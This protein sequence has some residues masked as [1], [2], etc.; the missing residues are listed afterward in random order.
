[1]EQKRRLR[2]LEKISETDDTVTFR[3]DVADGQP[4]TY[5]P[6]QHVTLIF[7]VN[8]HEKRRA[9]S[10]SSSPAT[11][12]YPA[13]TVKRV[14]NGEFS[15]LLLYRRAV[16]E[17]FTTTEANG[18]FLLPKRLPKSLFYIAAG[19]GITPIFSHLKTLLTPGAKRAGL[20]KIVLFYAN[21]DSRST[22][23]KAQIDRWMADYPGL[24]DC[25]YFFSREKN[26]EHARFRHLNNEL[27]EQELRRSFGGQLT[28]QHRRTSLFY[29][30]APQAMMRTARMTLRQ[31]DFPEENMHFEAFAPAIAPTVRRINTAVTH[32]IIAS[33]PSERIEFQVFDDETI[34]DGALR[35]GIALPYSCK[36]GVC[37]T[38]LT[39][40]VQGEVDM[41]FAQLT[42]RG[43]PGDM[44]NTCIGYAA[45]DSV[46]IRYE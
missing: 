4:F 9:Y 2:L 36:S 29:F 7:E 22:I 10:F 25:V 19:S 18:H 28:A 13:I 38:C 46:E 17:I 3:L 44:V 45:T 30:C 14:P 40:C 20:Q 1:M 39:R 15:N 34:L 12:T 6:G 31:L 32:R 5:L 43:R 11:D 41:A 23:F 33:S 26:A 16:G 24:F 35:Q 42:Q 21:R 37:L 27:L 8:G